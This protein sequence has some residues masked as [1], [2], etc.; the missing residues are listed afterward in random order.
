MDSVT[1]FEELEKFQLFLESKKE[2][3]FRISSLNRSGI[4]KLIDS[5]ELL[6]KKTYFSEKNDIIENTD[7]SMLKNTIWND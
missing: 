6:I 1:D 4:S 5:I 2:N 7:S 3:V